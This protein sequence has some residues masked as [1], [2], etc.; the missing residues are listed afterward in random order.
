MFRK[1]ESE[2]EVVGSGCCGLSVCL[3]SGGCCL[4]SGWQF[5][6]MTL[7]RKLMIIPVRVALHK[8]KHFVDS[9][10]NLNS[11]VSRSF[12]YNKISTVTQPPPPPPPPPTQPKTLATL[13]PPFSLEFSNNTHNGQVRPRQCVPFRRFGDSNSSSSADDIYL[14]AASSATTPSSAIPSTNPSRMRAWSA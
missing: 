7:T 8:A 10:Q 2:L 14:Q 13:L 4:E 3:W 11:S 5:I 6:R 1:A 12:T 9:S